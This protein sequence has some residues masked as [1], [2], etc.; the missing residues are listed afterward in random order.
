MIIGWGQQLFSKTLA[1]KVIIWTRCCHTVHETTR[2]DERLL[3]VL[4]LSAEDIYGACYFQLF[5]CSKHIFGHEC[6]VTLGE[7]SLCFSPAACCKHTMYHIT[8]ACWPSLQINPFLFS[9]KKTVLSICWPTHMSLVLSSLF[10]YCR[11]SF[12][13]SVSFSNCV[14]N[15]R[16]FCLL[17][18]SL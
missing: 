12:C 15:V 4:L 17:C 8:S 16:G 9:N 2:W 11:F 6:G 18:V 13:A 1:S 5:G 7:K 10:P 3:L 14:N